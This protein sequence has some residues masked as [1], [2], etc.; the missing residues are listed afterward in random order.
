MVGRSR[1]EETEDANRNASVPENGS[2]AAT[3]TAAAEANS[4]KIKAGRMGG[5]TPEAQ[6]LMALCGVGAVRWDRDEDGDGGGSP[7][8]TAMVRYGIIQSFQ[9]QLY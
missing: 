8:T 6:G 1:Y 5:S 2:A 4:S 9:H 3:A 7:A